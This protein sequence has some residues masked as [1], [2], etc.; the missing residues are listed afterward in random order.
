MPEEQ[1]QRVDSFHMS[2]ENLRRAFTVHFQ[3]Y[4]QIVTEDI[5]GLNVFIY[6]RIGLL[7]VE[8][9]GIKT[10]KKSQKIKSVILQRNG[11]MH[12]KWVSPLENSGLRH[13]GLEGRPCGLLSTDG[14][15]LCCSE[16]TPGEKGALRM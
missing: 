12:G 14:M 8:V 6:Y 10:E 9:N 11:R 3:M 13:S 16:F 15:Y 2:C 1:Q 7:I 4:W 5:E